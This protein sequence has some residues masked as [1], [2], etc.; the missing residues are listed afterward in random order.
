MR[1]KVAATIVPKAA[2][3]R[4]Q[5]QPAVIAV[6]DEGRAFVGLAGIEKHRT[7]DH[8]GVTIGVH[9]SGRTQSTSVISLCLVTFYHPGR[10]AV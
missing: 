10:Q 7:H 6:V 4:P 8:I 2:L 9:I 3:L 1:V 5:A